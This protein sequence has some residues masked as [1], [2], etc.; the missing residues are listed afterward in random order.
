MIRVRDAAPGDEA[1]WRA[2]WQGYLQFY[3]ATVPDP[4]TRFTWQRILDP[5][6]PIFAR[7]AERD[8]MVAGFAVCVLH[9]GTFVT[10][11]ICYLEDLFVDPNSRRGGVATAF[12][13]DL[14]DLGRARGWSRLYWHTGTN[15]ATARRIYDR[16][17]KADDFVRYQMDLR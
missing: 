5:A 10:T 1:D 17:A 16:F 6:S 8:G 15:N 9:E 14:V 12:I 11:P 4:V 3:Q 13:Q 7:I 2:L